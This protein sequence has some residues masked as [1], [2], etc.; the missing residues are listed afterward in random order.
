MT[1]FP[2]ERLPTYSFV[3]PSLRCNNLWG[4]DYLF[5]SRGGD[6]RDS[7]G[8]RPRIYRGSAFLAAAGAHK[9]DAEI[10][11]KATEIKSKFIPPELV[12][13]LRCS[14]IVRATGTFCVIMKSVSKCKAMFPKCS[15]SFRTCCG[16]IENTHSENGVNAVRMSFITTFWLQWQPCSWEAVLRCP[17]ARDN[18]PPNVHKLHTGLRI[19]AT[20]MCTE[21]SD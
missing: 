5:T 14:C 20:V 12:S 10:V 13:Q 9:E 11:Q 1:F 17:S 4:L 8:F 16:D 2:L 18:G 15:R 7:Q 6:A 21:M 3:I 19:T